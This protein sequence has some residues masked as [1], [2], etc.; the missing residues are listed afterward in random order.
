MYNLT[1]RPKNK[2]LQELSVSTKSVHHT[3]SKQSSKNLPCAPITIQGLP[4]KTLI[5]SASEL[6]LMQ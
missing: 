6:N 4:I 3:T 2:N 5:D 1:T